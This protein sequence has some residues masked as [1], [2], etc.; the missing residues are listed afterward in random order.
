MPLIHRRICYANAGAADQIV[1]LMQNG[2]AAM[3]RYG[4][5]RDSRILTDHMTGR[6]DRVVVE[7]DV[8]DMGSMDAA[9]RSIMEDPEGAA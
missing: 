4:S 9:L 6:S 8:D 7:W 5:S 1:Q 3:V 2:R